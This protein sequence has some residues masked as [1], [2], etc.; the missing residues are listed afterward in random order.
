MQQPD[1]T[2]CLQPIL[3]NREAIQVEIGKAQ[4][5]LLDLLSGGGATECD[6]ATRTALIGLESIQHSVGEMQILL[7]REVGGDEA[8]LAELDNSPNTDLPPASAVAVLHQTMKG[9]QYAS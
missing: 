7:F 4:L 5:A 1:S 2:S 6:D 3:R 9:V 8:A